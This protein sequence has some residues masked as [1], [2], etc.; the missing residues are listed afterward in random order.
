M[1][2][3]LRRLL[4]QPLYQLLGYAAR[5]A[6]RMALAAADAAGRASAPFRSDTPGRLQELFPHLTAQEAARLL[7]HILAMEVRNQMLPA[8][9]RRAVGRIARFAGKIESLEL[10]AILVT[11]HIGPMLALG[12]LLDGEED[13]RPIVRSYGRE[14]SGARELHRA[15][16][17]LRETRLLGVAVDSWRAARVD[18]PFFDTTMGIARGAFAL[19]RIARVPLVPALFVW[20]GWEIDVVLGEPVAPPAPSASQEESLESERQTAAAIVVWLEGYL[21]GSLRDLGLRAIRKR[22]PR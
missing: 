2:V 3:R 15:L 14:L 18:V 8:M 11:F 10:P 21:R 17:T 12:R 6:P 1:S 7:R 16:T 19:S 9:G 4:V 20:R 22:R 5:I 13:N